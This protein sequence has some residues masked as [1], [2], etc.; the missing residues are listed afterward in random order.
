M[1]IDPCGGLVACTLLGQHAVKGQAPIE[2]L[3]LIPL[4]RDS[5]LAETEALVAFIKSA[6][7]SRNCRWIHPT[8]ARMFARR[9]K[10]S[11]EKTGSLMKVHIGL[12]RLSFLA[13]WTA[14]G[15]IDSQHKRDNG[16]LQNQDLPSMFGTKRKSVHQ[17]L[18]RMERHERQGLDFPPRRY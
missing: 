9:S 8:K 2:S 18:Q 12:T 3:A 16:L 11:S 4:L 5:D 6:S 15:T 1:V 17:E 13:A 10:M 14:A 7:A